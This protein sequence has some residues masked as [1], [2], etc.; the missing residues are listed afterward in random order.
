[1]LDARFSHAAP[2]YGTIVAAVNLA[3]R[4]NSGASIVMQLHVTSF[5]IP[6]E[7]FKLCSKLLTVTD[8][9]PILA[10]A[11]ATLPSSTLLGTATLFDSQW[12]DTYEHSSVLDIEL[13]T[14]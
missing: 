3:I 4:P 12:A 6:L 9:S 5:N 8:A 2:H 1:M 10:S 14:T 11:D 13:Y 7:L